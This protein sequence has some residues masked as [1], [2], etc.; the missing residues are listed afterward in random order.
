MM[1][2]QNPPNS[3]M[4]FKRKTHTTDP[5]VLNS[6][7]TTVTFAMPAAAEALELSSR[8]APSSP[9]KNEKK[10]KGF[11]KHLTRPKS[12]TSPRSHPNSDP[13][14]SPS[15]NPRPKWLVFKNHK[16][17]K[18]KDS[19]DANGGRATPVGDGSHDDLSRTLEP[20]ATPVYDLPG[21]TPPLLKSASGS[22][23]PVITVSHSG[24][25]EVNL[26]GSLDD[27]SKQRKLSQTSHCS[28]NFPSTGTS[29]VGSLLSPSGDEG[30]DLESPISPL[31][32]RTSSFTEHTLGDLSDMEL[33][34][35]VGSDPETITSLQGSSPPP[36][37]EGSSPTDSNHRAMSPGKGALGKFKRDKKSSEFVSSNCI[38]RPWVQLQVGIEGCD[39]LLVCFS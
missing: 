36:Q 17:K 10:R 14:R 22:N 2:A 26:S 39:G 25:G 4:H 20:V 6:L 16:R 7:S 11:L 33:I 13:E 24:S 38:H 32:S 1:A 8:S 5:L 28:S 3:F 19:K 21:Q 35:P 29:G 34:S 23:I 37:D 31:S 15:P 12:P 27:V 30:Y 18:S 9:V